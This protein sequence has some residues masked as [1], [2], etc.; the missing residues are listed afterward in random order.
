MSIENK[1]LQPTE[2]LSVEQPFCVK[3][4]QEF[5]E[6]DV[7]AKLNKL[8]EEEEEYLQYIET[9]PEELDKNNLVRIGN[10]VWPREIIEGTT[11]RGVEFRNLFALE[12]KV[13]YVS[14]GARDKYNTLMGESLINI[15][16]TYEY[17]EGH[18]KLAEQIYKEFEEYEKAV[19]DVDDYITNIGVDVLRRYVD[20]NRQEQQTVFKLDD[21]VVQKMTKTYNEYDTNI[22][23]SEL[24]QYLNGEKEFKNLEDVMRFLDKLKELDI[25]IE[26]VERLE[27]LKSKKQD[28]S[29]KKNEKDKR[30]KIIQYLTEKGNR[31]RRNAMQIAANSMNDEVRKNLASLGKLTTEQ[32]QELVENTKKVEKLK[33]HSDFISEY[34]K[35]FTFRNKHIIEEKYGVN[36]PI[37]MET[38][39]QLE[40]FTK[41][42]LAIEKVA[43]EFGLH[44]WYE[45]NDNIHVEE[46][47]DDIFPAID[48][49]EI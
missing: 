16:D 39:E 45:L 12:D 28:A 23:L 26:Q 13:E 29:D 44:D 1:S 18:K 40:L 5:V 19:K 42:Q 8:H 30:K 4:A 38:I 7:F 15:L 48:N 22:F 49:M 37:N 11:Q 43:Q 20:V 10:T 2:Q 14:E 6:S 33:K 9:H 32:L 27:E 46:W 34:V 31:S 36:I 17:Y 24:E 41:A 3:T 35:T 21:V 47:R 25:T